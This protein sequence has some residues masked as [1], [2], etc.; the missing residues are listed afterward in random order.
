LVAAV[1]VVA[2][3]NNNR[4][5]AAVARAVLALEAQRYLSVR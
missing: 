5:P 4:V 1:L 2:Q 3:T